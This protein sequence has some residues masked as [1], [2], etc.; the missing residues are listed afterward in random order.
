MPCSV[1]R[2]E[3]EGLRKHEQ[4]C[5]VPRSVGDPGQETLAAGDE[6][7]ELDDIGP[8]LGGDRKG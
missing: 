1:S 2:N 7:N 5:F 3:S 4:G 6:G 8:Q